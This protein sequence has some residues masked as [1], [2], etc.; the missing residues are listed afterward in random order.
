[1]TVNSKP[2]LKISKEGDQKIKPALYLVSTPIG[3]LQDMTYRAVEIL[4]GVDEIACEDTR[5]TKKL[6]Q[7]FDIQTP[8]SSYHEHSS[9]GVRDKIITKIER[10]KS[11]ALVSDAGTPLISDPGY[12]LVQGCV[13]KGI[14]VIPIPGASSLLPALQ[15]SG[16][17]TNQF[18]F[19]GFL[20]AK[21]TERKNFLKEKK[22][23]RSTLLFFETPHR[24]LDSLKDVLEVLGDREIALAKEITKIFET[25]K[26][27]TI[28]DFLSSSALSDFTKGEI[29][30]VIQGAQKNEKKNIKEVEEFLSFLLKDLSLK[31]AVDECVASTGYHKKEIYQMA[32]QIKHETKK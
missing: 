12:K 5:Q 25:V 23:I 31:Q 20:P 21:T 16:L 19:C 9:S 14:Q 18:C 32:L 27:G 13:K 8:L 28:K 30:L 1:M 15:V 7:A 10:G 26:R 11:M 29:V 22:E 6:C 2:L 3:N 17:P 24:L 4:E